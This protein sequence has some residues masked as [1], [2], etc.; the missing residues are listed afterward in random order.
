MYERNIEQAES[1]ICAGIQ[2]GMVLPRNQTCSSEVVLEVLKPG[3]DT[4]VDRHAA[5]DQIFIIMEGQGNLMIGDERK[6][7]RPGSVCYIPRGTA[8]SI[9]CT[10]AGELRYLYINVWPNGIPE[11]DRDWKQVYLA[12][13]DRR[14]AAG[15]DRSVPIL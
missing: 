7:V 5:F 10:S 13:H 12:I 4:P 6:D 8:H 2:F 15:E 1:F 11:A 9:R 3:Q 14:R